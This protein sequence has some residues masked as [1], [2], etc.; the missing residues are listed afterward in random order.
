[1]QLLLITAEFST[2][3]AAFWSIPVQRTDV[4]PD[5]QRLEAVQAIHMKMHRNIE[6]H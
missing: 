2:K 4:N 5:H 3:D 6:I 1:M